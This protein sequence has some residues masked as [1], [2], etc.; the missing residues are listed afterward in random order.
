MVMGIIT[1]PSNPINILLNAALWG[2]GSVQNTPPQSYVLTGNYYDFV[3]TDFIQSNSYVLTSTVTTAGDWIAFDIGNRGTQALKLTVTQNGAMIYSKSLIPGAIDSFVSNAFN[4]NDV[5]QIKV[6]TTDGTALNGA[7]NFLIVPINENLATGPIVIYTVAIS[8]DNVTFTDSSKVNT[9]DTE[10]QVIWNFGDTQT[11]TQTT[12]L[13]TYA[14]APTGYVPLL[15]VVDSAGNSASR[16]VN[17]FTSAPTTASF[18]VTT[19][20]LDITCTNTSSAGIA[21]PIISYVW[22]FG[23]GSN[24]ILTPNAIHTYGAPGTF[25]VTLTITDSMGVIV[26]TN[27]QVTVVAVGSAVSTYVMKGFMTYDP[28]DNNAVNAI[29]SFGELSTYAKTFSPDTQTYVAVVDQ[30]VALVLFTSATTNPNNPQSGGASSGNASF[31]TYQ[32]PKIAYTNTALALGAWLYSQSVATTLATNQVTLANNIL[33]E[34]TGQMTNIQVGVIIAN[35]NGQSMP[36]WVSYVQTDGTNANYVKL[37][38][39][40]ASFREQYD[41]YIIRVVPPLAN[42]DDFFQASTTVIPE[43]GTISLTTLLGQAQQVSNSQPYTTILAPSYGYLNPNNPIA[44][45]PANFTAVP[46]PVLIYGQAGDNVDSIKQALINYILANSTH[47]ENQWSAIFPDIFNTTEFIITPM[48]D[49]YSVPNLTLDAGVYSPIVNAASAVTIAQKTAIGPNYTASY[50]GSNMDVVNSAY[51]SMSF[52]SIGSPTNRNAIVRLVQQWPDYMSVGTT[53]PDFN[54][55][56]PATQQWIMLLQLLFQ[57]AETMT[58]YS[59][60]PGGVTRLI[61]GNIMYAVANFQNVDYLVVSRQSLETIVPITPSTSGAQNLTLAHTGLV[62]ST[63]RVIS[64]QF[65]TTGQVG[66]VVYGFTATGGAPAGGINANTGALSL[67]YTNAGT[68]SITVTATD[69]ATG[70]LVSGTYSVNVT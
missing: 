27:Q 69:N 56:Q 45:N 65:S 46:W 4:L 2:D 6:T 35:S 12:A 44:T 11:V 48:W 26:T 29:A 54:R 30:S 1:P 70:A 50:I 15:A 8:G 23:D 10:S 17:L 53:N 39:S 24:D 59:D 49:Q 21:A 43:I 64:D 47:T 37:W 31:M 36:E 20:G 22:N 18:N 62:Q 61:R 63:G 67:T 38:F 60:L 42:L 13:H 41:Q 57:T 5:I 52:L 55:M 7:E 40:D 58:T 51:K 66:T 3:S 34:F 16:L 33:A 14:T 9:G 25:T 19:S 28:L 32:A 68:Y